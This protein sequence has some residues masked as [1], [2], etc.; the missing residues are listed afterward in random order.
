MGLFKKKSPPAAS[1]EEL[2]SKAID[3]ILPRRMA[4]PGNCWKGTSKC[5][6][7]GSYDEVITEDKARFSPGGPKAFCGRC[8]APITYTWQKG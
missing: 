3:E 7:C 5:A 4:N 1:P 2:F 8:K 6:R